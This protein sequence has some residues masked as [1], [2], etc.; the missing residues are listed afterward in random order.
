VRVINNQQVRTTARHRASNP[1]VMCQYTF[2]KK[3]VITVRQ[4]VDE[5]FPLVRGP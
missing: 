1:T 2:C 3:G 5:S 4:E